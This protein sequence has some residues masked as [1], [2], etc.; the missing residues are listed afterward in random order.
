MK[1][2]E[3]NILLV[4]SIFMG[5][6]LCIFSFVLGYETALMKHESKCPELSRSF[7]SDPEYVVTISAEYLSELKE[8]G[9][10]WVR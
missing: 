9:A 6:M 8:R 5:L 1:E 7:T 3:I 10:V 4:L 2:K